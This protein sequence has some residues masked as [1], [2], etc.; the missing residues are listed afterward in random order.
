[1]LN[2]D[3]AV[4]LETVT[5]PLEPLYLI[6][7]DQPTDLLIQ[8]AI[9]QRPDL[10]SR[11]AQIAQSEIRLKEE[12]TRPL[13]P[14]LWLGFSGGAFGGGSNL[15]PPLMSHFGPRTDFDVRATW[16]LLNFGAGNASLIKRRRAEVGEAVADRSR[17]VNALRAEVTSAKAEA[18]AQRQKVEIGRAELSSAEAGFR[19]DFQRLRETVGLPIEVIDSL[20][21][22][23]Q[24]R[25]NFI[26]AVTKSNKAQFALFV[27]LGTPPPLDTSAE[28]PSTAPPIATPLRSPIVWPKPEPSPH[29]QAPAPPSL[30]G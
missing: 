18:L 1:V 30:G 25:I 10:A 3:A 27:S 6:D 7:P 24:A 28:S 11:S 14:T 17:T 9:A 15:A 4:R 19:E 16:T 21:L 29:V 20:K 2:L 8:T 26:D 5:G 22:L 23:A 12:Q 13:L